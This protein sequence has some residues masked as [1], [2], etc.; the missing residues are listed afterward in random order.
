MP[1]N[2]Y[3]VLRDLYGVKGYFLNFYG[4]TSVGNGQG[5][6]R[7]S[8]WVAR[9]QFEGHYRV[10][11]TSL[12]KIEPSGDKR[13]NMWCFTCHRGLARPIA[14]SAQITETYRADGLEASLNQ[15]SELKE[16][17]YGTG[18]YQFNESVLNNLG[19]AASSENPD[20]DLNAWK[21]TS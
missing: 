14:F 6:S 4:L 3:A 15:Y 16:K 12:I 18:A 7:G 13:V 5:A 2:Y 21:L 8:I 11:G 1:V 9:P 20:G 19:Y 10:S 17:Y